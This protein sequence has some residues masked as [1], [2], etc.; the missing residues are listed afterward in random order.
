MT[1]ASV[2]P[3]YNEIDGVPSHAN[4]WLLE[5]VLVVEQDPVDPG[6]FQEFTKLV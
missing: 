2:M 4:K 6:Q 1:V 5:G 3:S